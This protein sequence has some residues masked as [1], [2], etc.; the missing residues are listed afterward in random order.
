MIISTVK[1]KDNVIFMVFVLAMCLVYICFKHLF[2][3]EYKY[4]NNYI[5]FNLLVI[6]FILV[7]LIIEIF[8]TRKRYINL[9]QDSRKLTS[10]MMRVVDNF[11]DD[12]I[13]QIYGDNIKIFMNEE[14]FSS[15]KIYT[16][17]SE[18]EMTKLTN[19][20]FKDLIVI[21]FYKH[22][23]KII[24][25]I[26]TFNITY[27]ICLLNVQEVLFNIMLFVF[28]FTI[29]T[30]TKYICNRKLENILNKRNLKIFIKAH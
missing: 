28:I 27:L 7:L 9:M 17:Y 8:Y 3:I 14:L 19:L 21:F 12:Y 26:Y 13:F 2:E 25:V 30:F 22:F 20:N 16:D 18:L 29:Y 6:T 1:K 4:L 24:F 11:S 10:T 23:S 5:Y 15:S